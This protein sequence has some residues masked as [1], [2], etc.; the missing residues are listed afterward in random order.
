[1]AAGSRPQVCPA[2]RKEASGAA[3]VNRAVWIL[4]R[5]IGQK[6]KVYWG[7]SVEVGPSLG[8]TARRRR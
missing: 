7:S 5:G 2:S 4:E 3:D 6:E 8:V 1:M